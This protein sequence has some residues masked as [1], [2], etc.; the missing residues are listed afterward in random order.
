MELILTLR[1][2]VF[3]LGRLGVPQELSLYG[4]ALRLLDPGAGGW[5]RATR[6]FSFLCAPELTQL[7]AGDEG[8]TSLPSPLSC[9]CPGQKLPRTGLLLLL[10]P[11]WQ[12]PAWGSGQAW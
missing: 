8:Q 6:I 11:P 2:Q 7:A 10:A 1:R 12:E 9:P 5:G 4:T 3:A